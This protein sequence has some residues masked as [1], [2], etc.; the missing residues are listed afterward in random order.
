MTARCKSAELILQAKGIKWTI[1][2]RS[3]R[4]RAAEVT[5][6]PATRC[7][8]KGKE[9]MATP[10]SPKKAAGKM[11]KK[12]AASALAKRKKTPAKKKTTKK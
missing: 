3:G 2:A 8:E 9:S 10:K 11:V 1:P 4:A 12:S 7:A 5:D 6:Y